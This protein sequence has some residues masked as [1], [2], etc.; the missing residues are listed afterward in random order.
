MK[1]TKKQAKKKTQKQKTLEAVRVHITLPSDLYDYS[2][3]LTFDQL[4]DTLFAVNMYLNNEDKSMFTEEG[5][6]AM[7]T[8]LSKNNVEVFRKAKQAAMV[9]QHELLEKEFYVKDIMS[10][11][12]R[13]FM[14]H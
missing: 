1:T 6:R 3:L 8:W 12:T 10:M 9:A 11:P 13:T 2:E 5:K 14:S 4:A 7:E